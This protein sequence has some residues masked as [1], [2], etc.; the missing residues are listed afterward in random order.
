MK[1]KS[2]LIKRRLAQSTLVL[3]IGLMGF[4]AP[5]VN[6]AS[7]YSKGEE[8]NSLSEEE[9]AKYF[10]DDEEYNPSI[11]DLEDRTISNRGDV[12]NIENFTYTETEENINRDIDEEEEE[13]DVPV[14][15]PREENEEELNDNPIILT[16]DGYRIQLSLDKTYYTIISYTFSARRINV[17]ERYNKDGLPISKIGDFAFANK[18]GLEYINLHQGIISIGENVFDGCESLV[19]NKDDNGGLYLGADDNPYYYFYST[20]D[21]EIDEFDVNE[22]TKIIG[23]NA[24][25]N[26]ENLYR[27]SFPENAIEVGYNALGRCYYIYDVTLPFVGQ[28]GDG[29]TNA[30]IGWVFGARTIGGN[31]SYLPS[32]LRILTI[33]GGEKIRKNA[34]YGLDMVSEITLPYLGNYLDDQDNG[35]LS[36]FWGASS[37][38]ANYVPKSIKK[39]SIKEGITTI[40][41][42]AFYTCSYLEE[43]VLPESVNEI[44]GS[45]FY[46]C[47]RLKK[48]KLPDTLEKLGV[49]TFANC[50]NLDIRTLPKGL[51]R[52]NYDTFKNCISLTQILIADSVERIDTSAFENCVNLNDVYFGENLTSIGMYA[53]KGCSSIE[54]IEMFDNVVTIEDYAFMDCSNLEK[55]TFSSNLKS[56]GRMSFSEDVNLKVI[57]LPDSLKTIGYSAFD[58]CRSVYA[59]TLG[60]SLYT[61]GEN[62]FRDCPN[63]IIVKN[64]SSLSITYGYGSS[65]GLT[66]YALI[67]E[68]KDGNRQYKNNKTCLFENGFLCID[69]GGTYYLTR[70]VGEEKT[71]TLPYRISD[72]SYSLKNVEGIENVIIPSTKL[73]IDQNAFSG[74]KTLKTVVISSGTYK[75]MSNA[76]SNCENLE[77]VLLPDTI[78]TIES[79]AFSECS[80]LKTV[81]IPKGLTTINNNVFKNCISLESVSIHENIT[82]INV[83]AFVGC[84]NI[85]DIECNNSNFYISNHVLYDSNNNTIC[86]V[87]KNCKN[88]IVPENISYLRSGIFANHGN[89]ESVT[90]NS[91]IY[92]IASYTFQNC[93]SLKNIQLTNNITSIGIGAFEGCASLQ[94]IV[95]P[96]SLKMISTGAFKDCT[97]LESVIFESGF[98][99]LGDQAFQNCASLK[100][101]SLPNTLETI[102]ASAFENCTSLTNIVLPDS[103]ETIDADCFANCTNLKY[104]I[105]PKTQPTVG[106][107]IFQNCSSLESIYI[108]ESWISIPRE[109][110]Q[111]CTSLSNVNL[112]NI[113]SIGTSAF[114]GCTSLEEVDLTK[115]TSFEDYAFDGCSKL[116]T[117]SL[118]SSLTSIKRWGFAGC[119]SL[120]SIVIPDSVTSIQDYAFYGCSSLKNI[121]LPTTLKTIGN[122]AFYDCISLVKFT[123]PSSVTSIGDY[124][125]SGCSSL[126]YVDAHSNTTI[127]INSIGSTKYG[128]LTYNAKIVVGVNGTLID[129]DSSLENDIIYDNVKIG[130]TSVKCAL[131]Y[132]GSNETITLPVDKENNLIVYHFTG[133]NNVII[134]EGV[135]SIPSEAFSYSKTLKSVT[136]PY[137]VKVIGDKA[138]YE[139]ANLSTISPLS[140]IKEIGDYSFYGCKSIR[141]ISELSNVESIGAYTFSKAGIDSY[142]IPTTIRNIG[143]SIFDDSNIS[144]LII[145]LSEKEW[146]YVHKSSDWLNGVDSDPVFIGQD[147]SGLLYEGDE[148]LNNLYI[149]GYHGNDTVVEIPTT[150]VGLPISEIY[151]NAFYK[152]EEITNLIIPD[153]IVYIGKNA[154]K[155][156]V[157]LKNVNIPNSISNILRGTFE[158]CNS[159]ESI[160]LPYIGRDASDSEDN[161]FGFI[162]G[163]YSYRENKDYVPKSLQNVTIGGEN[164]ISDYAF[165]DCENVRNYYFNSSVRVIGDYAFYNNKSL[166]SISLPDSLQIIK[167]YAFAKDSLL[168][169]ITIPDNVT[170]VKENIFY[171]CD[172]LTYIHIGNGLSYK[173]QYTVDEAGNKVITK[174]FE[175][176]ALGNALFGIDK[177]NSSLT[178]YHVNEDHPDLMVDRYGGLYIK[179]K[180]YID[181]E[182]KN[183]EVAV[184]D[185]PASSNLT[186][187]YLPEHIVEIY[188]YAFAYNDSLKDINLE[189]VREIKDY[190]FF[191]CTNLVRVV[192]DNT[193]EKV[194]E[195]LL[196]YVGE[197]TYSQAI[198]NYAFM[199]CIN[200]ANADLQSLVIERIGDGAFTDCNGLKTIIIGGNVKEIGFIAFGSSSSS[201]G[202]L[203]R[204]IVSQDNINYK[205]IDGVLYKINDD[206]SLTLVTYPSHKVG[207]ET[208]IERIVTYKT[209]TI[210]ETYKFLW[211]YSAREVSYTEEHIDY[212]TYE[213]VDYTNTFEL[214]T[215]DNDGNEV[216]VSSIESY[217]FRNAKYLTELIINPDN[218]IKVGD[219]AFSNSFLEHVYIGQNV[220]SLALRYG[221][222]EYTTFSGADYLI[223]IEVSDDN[224]FYSSYSGVLFNKDKTKLIKYP[225]QR[226]GREYIVP[227]SVNY[228]SSMAF[229]DNHNIGVVTINSNLDVIGLEA[230][231]GCNNIQVIYFN[232]CYAPRT[233]MENTFTIDLNVG[234]DVDAVLGY[235]ENYYENGSN[236]EIGWI[237]YKNIYNIKQY[238]YLP[239]YNINYKE[240]IYYAIAVV[241]T[242]GYGISDVWVS[243]TDYNGNTET[244]KSKDGIATFRSYVGAASDEF[245]LDF[246]EYYSLRIVDSK[247]EYFE[248]TSKNIILD[249]ETFITYITLTFRPEVYG[250]S[251][252][253]KEINS[254][255]VILN[256]QSFDFDISENDF[257]LSSLFNIGNLG[258]S[259]GK[260]GLG[261][262][263]ET[264]PLSVVAYFD[265]IDIDNI[266]ENSLILVQNSNPINGVL[267]NKFSID[268]NKALYEFEITVYNLEANVPLVARFYNAPMSCTDT[269]LNVKVVNFGFSVND[270]KFNF[271]DMNVDLSRAGDVIMKLLDGKSWNFNIGKNV[272][273][274]IEIEDDEITIDLT[275]KY[276]KKSE[277][278]NYKLPAAEEGF[279]SY[280]KRGN[281][282]SYNYRFV[283][284]VFEYRTNGITIEGV[285]SYTPILHNVIYDV[286]FYECPNAKNYFYYRCHI[287]EGSSTNTLYKFYGRVNG[288]L[289]DKVTGRARVG[290]K[291]STIALSHLMKLFEYDSDL[292]I[293]K[294]RK[295]TKN[296]ADFASFLSVDPK[297]NEMYT[298]KGESYEQSNH[299]FSI[300]L[301]GKVVLKYEDN[302]SFTM[303]SAFV[304]G[305]ISYQFTH[306]SQFV[307]WL[308]PI[309]L[310]VKIGI[311]G[312]LQLNLKLD[313]ERKLTADTVK[314]TVS[315]NISANLGVGCKLLSAGVY[316][317]VGMVMVMDFYPDFGIERW[318][319]TGQLGVYAKFLW[320]RKDYIIWEGSWEQIYSLS[321]PKRVLSKSGANELSKLYIAS[322]Y[323]KTA[324]E[325]I[326]EDA[327]L[328]VVGDN[329]YKV[330]YKN[331]NGLE[332]YDENNFVKLAVSKWNVDHWEEEAVLDDN[333]LSDGSY[334]LYEEGNKAYIIYVQR[335]SKMDDSEDIYEDMSNTS[336][337][338]AVINDGIIESVSSIPN[339]TG[340]YKYLEQITIRNGA[341]TAVWVENSEN[342]M[343]GVSK[344]NYIDA[345]G[346][347][348]INPTSANSIWISSLV[349]GSWSVPVCVKEGLSAITNIVIN[350]AGDIYYVEDLDGDLATND[351]RALYVKRADSLTHQSLNDVLEGTVTSL[352]TYEDKVVFEYINLSIEEGKR[353]TGFYSIKNSSN[354]DLVLD[355]EK[356]NEISENYKVVL[357]SNKEVKV[358]VYSKNV[359]IGEGGED[360]GSALFG[361]FFNNGEWGNR[362]T[363]V[364]ATKDLYISSFD[365]KLIEH[366]SK[367][368]ITVS[369][370]DKDSLNIEEKYIIELKDNVSLEEY[371]LN[372][373]EQTLSF[374]LFNNGAQ[375]TPIYVV[376]EGEIILLT[377]SLDSGARESFSI[378]IGENKEPVV[379]LFTSSTGEGLIAEINGLDFNYSDL[380]VSMKQI[381][382]GGKNVLLLAVKNTGNLSDNVTLSLYSGNIESGRSVATFNLGTLNPGEIC[383]K[384][385]VLEGIESNILTASIETSGEKEKGDAKDNNQKQISLNYM[386]RATGDDIVV[387]PLLEKDYFETTL[388]GINDILCPVQFNG[389]NVSKISL[390]DI[391]ISSSLYEVKDDSILINEEGLSQL[392]LGDNSLTIEFV[393]DD[394]V[395]NVIMNIRVNNIYNVTWS[396]INDGEINSIVTKVIENKIPVV[397]EIPQSYEDEHYIYSFIGW[398]HN[399]DNKVDILSPVNDSIT[400]N[401]LYERVGKQFNVT[402]IIDNKTYEESYQYLVIPSFKG[403]LN[404]EDK[405]FIGWDKEI[406][407]ITEDVI[408][409]ALFEDSSFILGDVDGN[410]VVNTRDVALL[411]QYI[412]GLVVLNDNQLRAANLYE[413][414]SEGK[415]IIN[416]RDLAKLQQL[417]IAQ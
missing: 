365:A 29:E 267:L 301:E 158:G 45:S 236:G 215:V 318:K 123:L 101:V 275:A 377:D 98:V 104:V 230:F 376:I 119:S 407:E 352:Y 300:G 244:V 64:N 163:A 147:N 37:Y 291:A 41:Y 141:D 360:N 326:S 127:Y 351:D 83:N 329:V 413:D 381:V 272:S 87:G 296:D 396:Y 22:N 174:G 258:F 312:A 91:R 59:V 190:A 103:L 355:E 336:L 306:Y 48:V 271:E 368:M 97:N 394:L 171:G 322:T 383:Y 225:S 196:E 71:V 105:L 177:S 187:Y 156:C 107:R 229:K 378:M 411:R 281:K 333:G 120:E 372:Y 226:Q 179:L 140:S 160:Q 261:I 39:V 180:V 63:L 340:K 234:I 399:G 232:H 191:R 403:N 195:E 24:F 96:S 172:S 395:H 309:T 157:N 218:E 209:V 343:F 152:N 303:S 184:V 183:I 393:K 282:G 319:V 358:Y 227:S 219:Y 256:K 36:Y 2:F 81:N 126:Y 51:I 284:P 69:T 128:R 153:T 242:S 188:N 313:E 286:R 289:N 252:N 7:A 130:D 121:V 294:P 367:L 60:T 203:E 298:P 307:V 197:K 238:N 250:V 348:H 166:E 78:T 73:S 264:I 214:P 95:L 82:T 310:E 320:W 273:F 331:M 387:I 47:S 52:I 53:F 328:Y 155:Y 208:K 224:E 90:L 249:E 165:Y 386:T 134:P 68:D 79:G 314:L 204:I 392:S 228:I 278:N 299:N 114:S 66:T 159:L 16:E 330:F 181:H 146:R 247:L 297:I 270:I 139:C 30:H 1:L 274:G 198:G 207:Y 276:N 287:Y 176:I 43:V 10:T 144:S 84:G 338:V 117:V 409:T 212:L 200:L 148:D 357:D 164:N 397:P 345:N 269:T 305:T 186:N 162:F 237:N 106:Y 182:Y 356:T 255:A 70:Y 13:E 19:F 353:E 189:Y 169:S 398:D 150:F 185:M 143:S 308:I 35:Y 391:E 292:K 417:V 385:T 161:Y 402:W 293:Y 415:P 67:I 31:L 373:S 26:Y 243:L 62:A 349:D 248:Y 384:D 4:G 85:S 15:V 194:P 113:T 110:F 57:N 38:Q 210:I 3:L 263:H 316:G 323:Q 283:L 363:L 401:A 55:I 233:I 412:V 75:I 92:E 254:E 240:S 231:Y 72:Y 99:S 410:G 202:S 49:E 93:T 115:L 262:Y 374:T 167:S 168:K 102:S 112:S 124:A 361:Y 138:F 414:C 321:S 56:I 347:T 335:T 337:K 8:D 201:S 246:T 404:I 178:E 288:S 216:Q 44:K 154:F 408:Y 5:I 192:F 108:P 239:R 213:I 405:N 346:E 118:S 42:G 94:S 61:I 277:T 257:S 34:F 268:G 379:K 220:T 136:L 350:N 332:G 211:H 11:S 80:S 54:T 354:V 12:I 266:N 375:S 28:F 295:C 193:D 9:I 221:E 341:L 304:K 389:Y 400:Y 325:Q 50:I 170:L 342:N 223:E 259:F 206:S 58:H 251:C 27:V 151:K 33:S 241:N 125:F 406:S 76:F 366:D 369:Y 17:P 390:N 205:D 222:G 18:V 21:K 135:K 380:I 6:I 334:M 74:S 32:S 324:P 359:V 100:I 362:V 175:D 235:S 137:T 86:L 149:S 129:D 131:A 46:S 199:G 315:A 145:S 133:V 89:L 344:D 388:E 109:M 371:S 339:L 279:N 302:N 327:S 260:D 280:K 40:C 132:I 14:I 23:A 173:G 285:E 217:A 116:K 311:D 88:L 25:D 382:I 65:G 317:N 416:T 265:P 290:I 20:E 142:I 122:S 364:E 253:G 370:T 111:D 245:A 77:S